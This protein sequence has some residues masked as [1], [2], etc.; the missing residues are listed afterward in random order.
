MTEK[1]KKKK[2]GKEIDWHK[3]NMDII[4]EE[5]ANDREYRYINALAWAMIY[6]LKRI[7]RMDERGAEAQSDTD[8]KSL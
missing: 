8:R 7:R 5:C 1:K 4:T 3:N 2:K 6:V